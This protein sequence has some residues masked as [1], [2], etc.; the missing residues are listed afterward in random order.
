MNNIWDI[1]EFVLFRANKEQQ[2]RVLTPE[3]FNL[4]C[5]F[6]DYELMKK[7]YGLPESY[8][9]GAPVP[10]MAWEITQAITDALVHLKVVMGGRDT[11][12]LNVDRDGYADTPSDYLHC[13]S[14]S[15]DMYLNQNCENPNGEEDRISIDVVRDSDWDIRLG[16]HLTK[17]TL[18]NP[19]C[20]IN[21]KYMEFRPKTIN[22]VNFT[23]LRKPTPAVLGYT[24]DVNANIVYNAAT[25]TQPD[26]PQHMLN[27]YANVLYEWLA[28][29]ILNQ[30]NIGDAKS[31]KVNGY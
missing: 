29:N 11:P 25:S 13:S 4:A 7:W 2:G 31:R 5:K 22:Y 17:P 9:P 12:M 16:D 8:R 20:R 28:V 30:I 19:I 27:E 6:V 21:A 3:K 24:I 1:Y 23:Y 10:S 26:W 15:Y 18:E 14:L